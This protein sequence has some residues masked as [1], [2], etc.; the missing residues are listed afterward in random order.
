MRLLIL[1]FH[2]LCAPVSSAPPLAPL[3]GMVPKCFSTRP[4]CIRP[5]A[6]ECR[7]AI[8]LMRTADPGYSVI[9]GRDEIIKHA[10]RAF[11]VPYMWSS[12]P[13]NCIVRVDVTDS[14]ATEEVTLKSL[15]AMAEVV[16]RKCIIGDTGC[17]GSVLIGKAGKLRLTVSY[18][19]AMDR[20]ERLL[21]WHSNITRFADD[22]NK[23]PL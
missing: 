20:V 1:L 5:R 18:Y 6:E 10:P 16:V 13:I 22:D 14:K 7:D 2:L 17:G 12:L 11:T 23:L 8:Y 9:L 21:V 4:H 19:T 3:T 15:A